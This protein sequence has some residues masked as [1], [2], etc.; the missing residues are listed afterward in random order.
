[1]R[2]R[3][4]TLLMLIAVASAMMVVSPQPAYADR[5]NPEELV[6]GPDNPIIPEEDNPVCQVLIRFV[7]PLACDDYSTL[8]NCVDSLKAADY[9]CSV[10]VFLE[11]N[12]V[13]SQGEHD[14]V[15]TL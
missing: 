8:A 1:M 3:I 7:Y 13:I 9:P 2:T 5:C 6:F 10:V 14:V 12:G 11:R 15:C 4:G